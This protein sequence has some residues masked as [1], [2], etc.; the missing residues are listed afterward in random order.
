MI[1]YKNTFE[2]YFTFLVENGLLSKQFS[3]DWEPEIYFINTSK[4]AEKSDSDL[5]NLLSN[6]A[7]VKKNKVGQTSTNQ[8]LFYYLEIIDLVVKR[9]E[10][11]EL[12]KNYIEEVNLKLNPS[13]KT[14]NNNNNNNDLFNL[15]LNLNNSRISKFGVKQ[16]HDVKYNEKVF[17][18]LSDIYMKTL[19]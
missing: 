19:E 3:F 16:L 8:Y 12:I 10:G 17:F 1:Q 2:C 18:F 5:N 7:G 14:S 6:F 15:N 4:E 13:K 9:K 11:V